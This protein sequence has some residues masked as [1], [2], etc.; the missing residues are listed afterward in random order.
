MVFL[1]LCDWVSGLGPSSMETT[2]EKIS[3]RSAF[4]RG[5]ELGFI[6]GEKSKPPSGTKGSQP[7]CVLKPL[8]GRNGLASPKGDLQICSEVGNSRG[9]VLVP[10]CP[11]PALQR[12]SQILEL[13][14]M[15]VK[16]TGVCQTWQ[17]PYWPQLSYYLSIQTRTKAY[18]MKGKGLLLSKLPRATAMRPL[19]RRGKPKRMDSQAGALPQ[20]ISTPRRESGSICPYVGCVASHTEV[21]L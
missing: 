3:S 18:F 11:L 13:F 14:S 7:A 17:A 1:P 9:R 16:A 8:F 2:P 20:S 10:D 15:K 19:S 5:W 6:G 21:S 12:H 4:P